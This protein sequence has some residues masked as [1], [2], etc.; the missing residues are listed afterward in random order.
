MKNL[1]K[2]FYSLAFI[3]IAALAVWNMNISSRTDF[4]LSDVILANVE[5]LASDEEPGGGDPN[6]YTE[7]KDETSTY[8]NGVLIKESVIITCPKGGTLVS[9]SESCKYRAKKGD[10]SWTDWMYF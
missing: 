9:C 1:I 8:A 3:M 2:L 6:K 7:I 10:G 5:A 4:L